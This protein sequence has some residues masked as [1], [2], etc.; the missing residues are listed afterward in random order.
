MGFYSPATLVKDA[1]RHGLRILPIDVARSGWLCSIESVPASGTQK[2][3]LALRLGMNYVRGLREI[4]AISLLRE[5]RQHRF[6]SIDD[7]ARRVR[8]LQKKELALL[9]EVGALNF[10]QQDRRIHRRDALWQ[11]E[12]AARPSGP[13]FDE[14]IEP[15]ISSPL[16]AMDAGERLVSDYRVSGL[17]TGPHPMALYR[18]QLDEMGVRRAMDLKNLSDGLWLRTAGC[19]IARQ[20]PGTARGFVFLSLEDE[21]GISNAIF[22]PDVLEKNRAV[23]TTERFLLIEG[24]L[25]HQDNVISVKARRVEALNVTRAPTTSRDFH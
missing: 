18:S 23:I 17:T 25:Q 19:V 6:H 2:H 11:I 15:D 22:T 9:A 1:V 12:R 7:L 3:T 13:L 21:T 16:R 14:I 5:R 24:W 8:E 10:I 4:A 20:R